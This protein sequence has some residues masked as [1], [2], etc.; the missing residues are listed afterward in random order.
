M[1]KEEKVLARESKLSFKDF[2]TVNYR[3]GEPEEIQYQD[4]RQRRTALGG[5]P[6]EAL[7]RQARLK[8]ARIMKRN[9]AKIERG[10]R[11]AR[12][13]TAPLE[14]LKV[15]ARKAARKLVFNKL[16]RDVPKDEM[17]FTRRIEIE[18]RLETPAMKTRIARLAARMLKDVRR[19]EMERRAARSNP[20]ND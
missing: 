7:T 6:S 9:K 14:K 4:H 13:R 17:S 8:R 15:R 1:E 16:S 12:M 18:K 11:L 5:G 19:K 3:P 20:N 10:Q 2:L